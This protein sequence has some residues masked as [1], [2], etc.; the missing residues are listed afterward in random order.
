MS[1]D[2]TTIIQSFHLT[3]VFKI[4]ILLVL[5]L[6]VL[7]LFVIFRQVRSMDRVIVQSFLGH[8][9]EIF[10]VVLLL[11]GIALFAVALAIL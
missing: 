7:F 6:Y 8:I 2:F 1:L 4:G 3:S 9:L 11:I 10:A 5:F